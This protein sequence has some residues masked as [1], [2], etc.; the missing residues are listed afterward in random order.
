M[1]LVNDLKELELRIWSKDHQS[2]LEQRLSK[3]EK[4]GM[5]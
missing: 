3:I 2:N 1:K 4:L 5:I